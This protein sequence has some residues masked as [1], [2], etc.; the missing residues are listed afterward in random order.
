[1]FSAAGYC[2][3][4]PRSQSK[5]FLELIPSKV[6]SVSIYKPTTTMIDSSKPDN[7]LSTDDLHK[8]GGVF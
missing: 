7:P 6:I 2:G 4:S 1:M 8:V 3:Q 5:E